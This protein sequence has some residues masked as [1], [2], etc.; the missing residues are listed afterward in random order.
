MMKATLKAENVAKIKQE[1]IIN[2]WC[3]K[4]YQSL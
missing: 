1:K 3:Y 2:I 4:N